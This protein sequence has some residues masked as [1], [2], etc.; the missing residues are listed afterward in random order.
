MNEGRVVIITGAAGGVGRV[1]TKAWIVSGAKVLAVDASERH[2]E[3]LKTFVGPTDRLEVFAADLSTEAG[4]TSMVVRAGKAFGLPDTLVHLVGGF[5]MGS[6]MEADAVSEFNKMLALNVNTSLNCF[7]AV[8][9]AFRERGGGWIVAMGSKAAT[10]PPAKVAAYSASKAAL[11]A[12]AQSMSEELKSE[13]IHINI[14]QA[15]TID[16]P[17]NRADMGDAS[18]KKWVRSEDVAEATLFLCSD[19]AG[20]SYGATLELY[21]QL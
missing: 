12:L 21:A 14:I 18:A 11:V 6:I 3:E 9:P 20:S 13:G 5:T 17:A 2:H 7:R 10:A 1:V 4:A 15:A 16:T 19:R 8:V